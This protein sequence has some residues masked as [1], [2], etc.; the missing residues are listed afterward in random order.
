MSSAMPITAI[1]AGVDAGDGDSAAM[2]NQR[3]SPVLEM[4]R[5]SIDFLALA[6]EDGRELIVRPGEFN[7]AAWAE[8][9]LEHVAANQTRERPVA[10]CRAIQ[11]PLG[12]R[13]QNRRQADPAT[14]VS[15][16]N[17]PMSRRFME[18][19]FPGQSMCIVSFRSNLCDP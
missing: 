17:S 13:V 5:N 6:A 12:D 14:R 8:A 7:D 15:P 19:L 9:S 2:R 4:M 16:A 18:M 11:V 3:F 10:L 1:A